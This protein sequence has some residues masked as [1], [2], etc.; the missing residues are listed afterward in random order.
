MH[1]SSLSAGK[2][3]QLD[4]A[5]S[6]L[7]R[8]TSAIDEVLSLFVSGVTKAAADDAQ[9]NTGTETSKTSVTHI[10]DIREFPSLGVPANIVN[11]PV[12]GQST[13]SQVSGQSDPTSLEFTLN[14]VPT[15][16]SSLESLRK[17]SALVCF[18]VRITDSKLVA[19]KG[20][21][22]N[23]DV[24]QA[25]STDIFDDFYFFGKVASFEV[26]T[27]L[28]D[29]LQATMSLTIEGDFIGPVSLVTSTASGKF[30]YEVLGT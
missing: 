10:G 11:V 20:D 6:G 2:F 15:I 7:V 4:Y 26:T 24:T 14:Y 8:D 23:V 12:Y 9:V 30:K 27:G 22:T 25:K 1:I 19:V 29:A 3:T 5:A 13:S 28:T 17:T 16:H 21:V 18:R